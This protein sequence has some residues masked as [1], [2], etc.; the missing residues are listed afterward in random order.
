MAGHADDGLVAKQCARVIIG[1]IFLSDMHAVAAEFYGKIR[2]IVHDEGH[3]MTLGD[4]QQG[5]RC[6]SDGI[7]RRG[8]LVGVLE[9][10]LQTGHVPGRQSVVEGLGKSV[11]ALPIQ[12]GRADQIET[13]A[14]VVARPGLGS[15]RDQNLPW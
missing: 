14:L 13:A 8:C 9:P 1:G 11:E 4:R 7:V 3:V 5:C 10:E 15:G 2:P 6:P 12:I